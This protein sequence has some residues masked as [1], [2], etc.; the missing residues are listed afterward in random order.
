MWRAVGA[1]DPLAAGF[2]CARMESLFSLLMRGWAMRL[3]RVWVACGVVAAVAFAVTSSVNA[4]AATT[5]CPAFTATAWQSPLTTKTVKGDKYVVTNGG[6]KYTCSQLK[7]FVKTLV[8]ERPS[9]GIPPQ[10][11]GV[12]KGWYCTATAD[13]EGLAFNGTCS[14]SKAASILGPG[15]TWTTAG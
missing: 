11:K 1:L 15:F 2:G 5:K 9:K 6:T 12:P 7:G 3:V 14:P 4:G 8:T 13:K 10:I